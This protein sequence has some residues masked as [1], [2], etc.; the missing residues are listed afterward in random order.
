MKRL[1]EFLW[2]AFSIMALYVI[3][4]SATNAQDVLVKMNG[5][6]IDIEVVKIQNSFLVY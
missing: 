3:S 2:T 1:L 4:I 6:S 5:D